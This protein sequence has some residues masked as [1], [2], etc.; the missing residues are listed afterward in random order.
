MENSMKCKMVISSFWE[1]SIRINCMLKLCLAWPK[2]NPLIG[3]AL[4]ISAELI[5]VHPVCWG[6]TAQT[7]A[8]PSCID[9]NKSLFLPSRPRALRWPR[10][11]GGV[12]IAWTL[13]VWH[14]GMT[15]WGDLH[16]RALQVLPETRSLLRSNC[17]VSGDTT[18]KP[19]RS[20]LLTIQYRT[21]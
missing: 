20:V 12:G 4:D 17:L 9:N 11:D 21:G 10:N 14:I 7:E 2:F 6:R 18:Y 15:R 1:E 3:D 19:I 8:W 16:N 13:P 5:R